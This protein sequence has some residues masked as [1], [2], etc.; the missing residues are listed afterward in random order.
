MTAI[1]I[2]DSKICSTNYAISASTIFERT[3]ARNQ[4]INSHNVHFYD[5]PMLK[6][7]DQLQILPEKN[8]Y[9]QHLRKNHHNNNVLTLEHLPD[10]RNKQLLKMG[11]LFYFFPF[12]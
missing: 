10:S 8:V 1:P 4:A 11:F 6:E 3:L 5:S 12:L 7:V 9:F 2:I